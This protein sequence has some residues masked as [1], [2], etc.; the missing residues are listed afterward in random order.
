MA[1]PR[2]AIIMRTQDRP[3]TLDRALSGIL[4]QSFTEWQLVLVSDAGNLVVTHIVKDGE[5]RAT[6]EPETGNYV[7]SVRFQ[8]RAQ[9]NNTLIAYSDWYSD[10][11]TEI[12]DKNLK[13]VEKSMTESLARFKGLIEKT[14]AA[15]SD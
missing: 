8:L 7:C 5:W 14:S 4:R 12:V 3:I 9:G 13:E 2:V 1:D 11:K 10:E 6:F 15:G